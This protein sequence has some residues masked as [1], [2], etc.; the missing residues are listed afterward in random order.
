MDS[1]SLARRLSVPSSSAHLL[2]ERNKITRSLDID[3]HITI[4]NDHSHINKEFSSTQEA[5]EWISIKSNY[6]KFSNKTNFLQISLIISTAIDDIKDLQLNHFG[7]E[8]SIFISISYQLKSQSYFFWK[9][10]DLTEI[11]S[12]EINDEFV[13]HFCQN[14]LIEE[15]KNFRTGILKTFKNK[16]KISITDIGDK[17]NSNLLILA[18]KAND[19]D[20]V[21]KLLYYQFD[22]EH[23]NEENLNAIECASSIFVDPIDHISKYKK[24][25]IILKL[26]KSNSKYPE[27]VGFDKNKTS[28]EVRDF[29]QFCEEIHNDVDEYNVESIKA[30][31]KKEPN[32][33]FIFNKN[34][35]SLLSHAVQSQSLEIR[36]L[37]IS[38]G[39][40]IATNESFEEI[41]E[42]LDINYCKELRNQSKKFAKSDP[43]SYLSVLK[44]KSE[45]GFNDSESNTRWKYV[46]DAFK[47]IDSN[48]TCS[49]ILKVAAIWKNT[50]I[51]FNF[52]DFKGTVYNSGD[53]YIGA[54]NL[55]DEE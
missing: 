28:K 18:S 47:L 54:L 12:F 13:A 37:L 22:V 29:I 3:N 7:N 41:Y 35:Q 11:Y 16:Q 14:Y 38:M 2:G 8:Y 45:I 42:E 6:E 48:E 46:E 33:K 24:D 51:F 34:N 9:V 26:L 55:L 23:K 30:K 17:N 36:K 15:I 20:L 44:L 31:I 27:N 32:L 53:I 10:R 52:K 49:K 43:K 50:K 25:Q 19:K 21:E 40:D 39:L 5:I 1:N 4:T